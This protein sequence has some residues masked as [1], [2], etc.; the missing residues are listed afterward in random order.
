MHERAA[1]LVVLGWAILCL[2]I[3]CSVPALKRFRRSRPQPKRTGESSTGVPSISG[4]WE[5]AGGAIVR[6]TQDGN[7]WTAQCSYSRKGGDIV[8]WDMSGTIDANKKVEGTLYHTRCPPDWKLKQIRDGQLSA[9]G[10]RITGK[11]IWEGGGQDYVW[12][13]DARI[14]PAPAAAAMSRISAADAR[15]STSITPMYVA[16]VFRKHTSIQANSILHVGKMV[17]ISGKIGEINE[18]TII[19]SKYFLMTFVWEPPACMT[20]MWF[21]SEWGERLHALKRGENVTIM[22]KIDKATEHTLP[23]SSCEIL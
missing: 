16:D 23:L 20:I 9:D 18:S 7:K 15:T 22:G 11:A 17:S 1:I 5:E 13:R 21:R 14:F 3:W 6:V 10:N 2:C 8:E 4:I 19:I 12:T